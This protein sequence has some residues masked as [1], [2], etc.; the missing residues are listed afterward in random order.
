[1]NKNIVWMVAVTLCAASSVEAKSRLVVFPVVS[2]AED[3]VP[4]TAGDAM[5]SAVESELAY[6]GGFLVTKAG[7]P[8][9][10]R[11]GKKRARRSGGSEREYKRALGELDKGD[12]Y[13]K[14]MRFRKAISAL[15]SGVSRLERNL[16]W[17][18]DY[19]RLLEARMLLAVSYFRR[20]KER[21][22]VEAFEQVLRL[23]PDRRLDAKEYPPV[24]TRVF[25]KARERLLS[26]RPGSL[27]VSA[28]VAGA[29][30]WLNGQ[31]LGRAP[32]RVEALVPGANH[33][34]VRS[35]GGRWAREVFIREGRKTSVEADLGGGRAA[36]GAL[37]GALEQNR[38][39]G[40]T[41]RALL[42]EAARLGGKYAMVL[43]MSRGRGVLSV[44]GFLGEVRSKRWVRLD[45][46]SPDMDM[47][48]ASIEAN[49]LARNVS[50]L[51]R[52]F[53]PALPGK[54]A[55]FFE[56]LRPRSAP[57]AKVVSFV[58]GQGGGVS[59]ARAPLVPKA[60]RQPLKP[61]AAPV[62]SVQARSPVRAAPAEVA[63]FMAPESPVKKRRA[64]LTRASA[65]PRKVARGPVVAVERSESLLGDS[66][67]AASRVGQT[68]GPPMAFRD[69]EAEL[70]QNG[71]GATP[72]WVWT[73][74]GAGTLAIA[75]AVSW[76]F[77]AQ[78]TESESVKVAVQW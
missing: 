35:Q 23:H 5:V 67:V 1:M 70:V 24:F 73:S 53:G 78:D 61:R 25:E 3:P 28:D 36:A 62:G 11:S 14:R 71:I 32:L 16:E 8:K 48:S 30:V 59:R 68:P 4:E 18:E 45:K 39:D 12:R 40:E 77:L 49:A 26:L 33:V 20:G 51:L 65:G 22:G 31:N 13:F 46:L 27:E 7:F 10:K 41:R 76:Y 54:T 58:K 56:G 37:A 74:V 19:E 57:S 63:S 72:W 66:Q 6:T 52:D 2:L 29:A 42:R 55:A 15:S 60:R 17:V 44:A 43:V 9:G 75:G 64:P 21:E 34:V 69:L 50:G 47:I 38:F